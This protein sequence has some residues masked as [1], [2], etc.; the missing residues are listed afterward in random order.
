MLGASAGLVATT[1][2]I[3]TLAPVLTTR[4]GVLPTVTADLAGLRSTLASVQR[5]HGGALPTTSQLTQRQSEQLAGSLG[6]ALEGVRRR[7]GPLTS[8]LAG[9]VRRSR[10]GDTQDR[11]APMKSPI[12]FRPCRSSSSDCV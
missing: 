2:V 9:E 8:P 12:S 6:Q 10:G 4:E 3:K 1:E 7:A 11:L 5:A